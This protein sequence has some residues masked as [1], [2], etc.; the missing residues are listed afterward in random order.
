MNA[1]VPILGSLA[2]CLL[3]TSAALGG[4]PNL[5]SKKFNIA[6]GYAKRHDLRQALD[7]L[8]ESFQLGYP[9]PSRVLEFPEFQ[10]LLLDDEAR[11]VLR[12]LLRN[13]AREPSV[14][15]VTT[16]EPGSPLVVSGFVR[17]ADGKPVVGAKIH[18][19][20]ADDG[21]RYTPSQAMNEPNARL[22]SF[23]VAGADG[24]FQF[25]T[26]RPGEYPERANATGDA[27]LIPRHVHFEIT[28]PG[29]AN[30]G[31]QMIFDDDQRATDYWRD[32]AKKM[33]NPTAHVVQDLDGLRHAS[34]EFILERK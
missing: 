2:L 14:N 33:R 24:K 19:F 13:H 4:G 18:V 1:N 11:K 32:W 20:H 12:E 3:A 9:V 16:S 8:R 31:G 26:V 5:A 7:T 25:R 30:Y 34:C 28:A 27:R 6:G 21:G 22:F 10:P 29:F 15:M 17:D 23:L